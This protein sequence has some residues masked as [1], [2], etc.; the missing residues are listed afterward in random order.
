MIHETFV[1]YDPPLKN[2]LKSQEKSG[3]ASI[4]SFDIS[5]AS[6]IDHPAAL[7]LTL[8]AAVHAYEENPTPEH[9]N[10]LKSLFYRIRGA[11]E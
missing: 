4:P 9:F 11:V 6:E 7:V 1:L 3:T 8:M 5:K 2:M 10:A